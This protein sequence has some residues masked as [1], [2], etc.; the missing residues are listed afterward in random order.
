MGKR[1]PEFRLVTEDQLKVGRVFTNRFFETRLIV[2]VHLISSK[3][4]ER[5]VTFTSQRQRHKES[6]NRLSSRG[7]VSSSV[8]SFLRWGNKK[9]RCPDCFRTYKH[10]HCLECGSVDHLPANCDSG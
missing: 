3:Q 5:T 6:T 8:K 4:E 1:E 2:G 10:V 7:I 9:F